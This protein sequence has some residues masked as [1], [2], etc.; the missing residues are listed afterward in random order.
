M[1][2]DNEI[3]SLDVGLEVAKEAFAQAEKLLQD[4]L[5]TKRSFEQ[6]ASTLFTAYVTISLALFGIGGTLLRDAGSVHR[7]VPFLL[8]GLVFVMGAQFFVWALRPA[9]YG[10]LGSD[11]SEWLKPDT[12]TSGEGEIAKTYACLVRAYDT[13]IDVSEKSNT[14]KR[15]LLSAGMWCGIAG[16]FTLLGVFIYVWSATEIHH[17]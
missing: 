5:E 16:T 12:L 4:V 2:T 17:P 9:E 14:L 10:N 7:A 13:R 1:L 11:P 6:R 15:R 3:R 8:A